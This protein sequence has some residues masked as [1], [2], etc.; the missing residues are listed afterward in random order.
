MGF[1][2]SLVMI[3]SLNLLEKVQLA[4]IR[5]SYVLVKRTLQRISLVRSLIE[6]CKLKESFRSIP[7]EPDRSCQDWVVMV[8]LAAFAE[9]VQ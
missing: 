8:L 6:N 3:T 2:S 4:H 9:S 5:H 1:N 7:D